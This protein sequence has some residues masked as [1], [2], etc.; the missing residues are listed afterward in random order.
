MDPIEEW[1][2]SQARV[3]E[4]MSA[5][6]DRAET[7]VPSCPAW[8]ARDL[9]SHMIGL[10]AD[11][12]AGDEP[13]DHNATWTQRQVDER[14]GR[15]VAALLDEWAGL[16]EPMQAWMRANNPRPM[17]DVV[18]HEQDLRGALGVPG[19]K[20][21]AGTASLRDTFAGRMARRVAAAGLP[22][23]ALVGSSWTFGDP[24]DAGLVLAADDF[25]LA[26]AVLSRRS[27]DQLRGWVRSGDL[28]PYLGLI[29][30]LGPLPDRDLTE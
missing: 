26:R 17:G 30:G 22:P 3:A 5:N 4:L 8:T 1:T 7:M 10:D 9:L 23:V 19:A 2:R 14:K 29:G 11:V 25:E 6:R 28:E 12:L 20:D 13:D 21:A 15:D 27:A 24:D 16:I 18:I